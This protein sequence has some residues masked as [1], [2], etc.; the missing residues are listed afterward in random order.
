MA[1]YL[2]TKGYVLRLII[3]ISFFVFIGVINELWNAPPGITTTNEFTPSQFMQ[4]S[5]FVEDTMYPN[6]IWV[7]GPQETVYS[8]SITF[9]W[10]GS[11][12]ITPSDHLVYSYTLQGYMTLWS[13]WELNTTTTFTDVP[14]GTYTFFVKSKDQAGNI[15]VSPLEETVTI[16]KPH[17]PVPT[18]YHVYTQEQKKNL[19]ENIVFISK[20]TPWTTTLH[21]PQDTVQSLDISLTWQDDVKTPLFKWGKDTITVTIVD[22]DNTQQVQASTHVSPIKIVHKQNLDEEIPS[23]IEAGSLEDA[24][25]HLETYTY[26]SWMNQP[27]T[28]MIEVEIGEHRLLRRLRDKGNEVTITVTYVSREFV[29]QDQPNTPPTTVLTQHP[30][31][32]TYQSSATFSWMGYDD[33]AP[34]TQIDYSYRLLPYE[35]EWSSWTSDTSVTFSELMPGTYHFFLKARDQLYQEQQEPTNLVFTI[36]EHPSTPPSDPEDDHDESVEP[37]SLFASEIISFNPGDGATSDTQRLLGG[38]RGKGEYEGSLDTLSLGVNGSVTLGFDVS[39]RDGTGPD[40]IVFEN[41][42]SYVTN[43]EII[44]G[45]LVCVEISTDG[46]HFARFPCKSTTQQPVPAYFGFHKGN[47][48]GCAGVSPVFAN[49]EDNDINPF[50]PVLAGGDTFDLADVQDHALV[51]S[52]V[53]DLHHINY[54]RLIDIHGDGSQHDSKGHPIFDPTGGMINGA[55]LDAVAVINYQTKETG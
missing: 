2:T 37:P 48:T 13:P 39:I 47:V 38:P 7:D 4:E 5:T 36:I 40:F 42:F 52:G 9:T 20:K 33:A 34:A 31:D 46:V 45:E 24:Q 6:T 53:I 27:W 21:I 19:Y 25:H 22:S 17:E 50:D 23:T 44:F 26:R 3:V 11:D 14:E 18:M 15:D 29:V 30:S 10:R 12:D 51:Q 35:V 8:S 16:I 28:L 41:P 32:A 55:D 1:S 43:P 54:V 49:V